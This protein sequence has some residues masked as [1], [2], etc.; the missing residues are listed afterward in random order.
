MSSSSSESEPEV[1]QMAIHDAPT[2]EHW[3]ARE[4][5]FSIESEADEPR[6]IGEEDL[7]FLVDGELEAACADDLLSWEIDPSSDEEEGEA[8]EPEEE[9]SSDTGYPPAKRLRGWAW[10]DDDDDEEDEDATGGFIS[11]DEELAGSSADDGDD[12]GGDSP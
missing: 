1:N 7:R 9:D 10:S 6:T 5:D 11:S 12:E 2:P 8:E 4:R 3:D